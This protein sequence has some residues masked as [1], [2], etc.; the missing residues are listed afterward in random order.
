MT[1]ERSIVRLI[2]RSFSLLDW[3]FRSRGPHL[4]H[5]RRIRLGS[6]LFRSDTLP[7]VGPD[8]RPHRNV[9]LC[10][11]AVPLS[12]EA[13][14][15][16]SNCIR[17]RLDRVAWLSRLW[18][19]LVTLLT[20]GVTCVHGQPGKVISHNHKYLLQT[21]L[22]IFWVNR[23]ISK[24]EAILWTAQERQ[25]QSSIRVGFINNSNCSV[26]TK[27]C[28]SSIF[29]QFLQ[30]STCNRLETSASEGHEKCHEKCRD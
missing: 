24:E 23:G 30:G 5:I 20:S 4:P 28:S 19:V 8:P 26:G 17:E 16:Q 21:E 11:D 9:L 3:S 25:A 29:V 14:M 6:D 10:A 12:W 18:C 1:P 2:G 7:F 13:R 22:A 27:N 15:T